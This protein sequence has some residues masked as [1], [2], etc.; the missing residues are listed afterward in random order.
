MTRSI[1]IIDDDKILRDTLASGLRKADFDALTAK[2]AEDA[3]EILN[4]VSVDAII[5]DRMMDGMDGLSFLKQIRASNNTTPVI[6]LTALSGAENAIDGLSG[7]ADDYMAKPFQFKEL[8][9]RL[10]N[11]MKNRRTNTNSTE[12]SIGLIFTDGDFFVIDENNQKKL[13]SLSNEEKK[14]L[15]TLTNPVG[16]IAT[17]TPMVAKR[18]RNK[19]KGVLSYIDIITVRG[20]GYKIVKTKI[21]I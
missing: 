20:M 21:G 7:G 15:Q 2:S 9:L 1:L 14:L 10:N 3:L 11:I 16:N 6:M 4:K 13:I 19:I 18:L 12:N 8:V 5:L 17:A